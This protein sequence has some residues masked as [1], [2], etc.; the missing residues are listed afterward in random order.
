MIQALRRRV[1][2]WVD[3]R[4]M[5]HSELCLD[6]RR[7]FILPSRVGLGF[8]LMLILMLLVAINYQNSLAYALTFLL[9]SV[10]L[11]ATLH[12]WRNLAGIRLLAQGSEPVFAGSQAA[13]GLRVE[14]NGR[15]RQALALGWAQGP[16]HIFDLSAGGVETVQ[17]LC[18]AP[19][20]GWLKAKRIRI[21]SRFPLGFW[22]A[23]SW[24]LLQQ[25]VLVYPRPETGQMPLL[26][27]TSDALEEEGAV[28]QRSGVD[29]YQGLRPY[30][31]GD[32]KRRLHWKAYSRGQGL[33]VKD[34]VSQ[35]S[36][37]YVLD[38]SRLDGE[39][40]ARLSVLCHWVLKLSEEDQAFSLVLGP[41]RY[42]PDSG[43][44]HRQR[45]LS[46]LALFAVAP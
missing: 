31:A 42:G 23:W 45:C 7:I 43:A 5:T 30:Q 33:L 12:T 2:A 29:D 17:L 44:T 21:E 28:Q 36:A 18:Q 39:L 22:V 26:D 34:F 16:L 38:I 4:L 40:E 24:V 35:D 20:R 9:A 15:E 41:E 27:A 11:L 19:H 3:K 32:S 8:I 13:I 25:K 37:E 46:A 14:G 6:Q 10:M 1:Q